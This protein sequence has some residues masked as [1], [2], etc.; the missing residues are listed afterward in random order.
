MGGGV[1]VLVPRTTHCSSGR[2]KCWQSAH[3]RPL[4]NPS[5]DWMHGFEAPGTSWSLKHRMAS[6][7]RGTDCAMNINAAGDKLMRPSLRHVGYTHVAVGLSKYHCLLC[8]T[9]SVLGRI[10]IS[11]LLIIC[12]FSTDSET[13][14]GIKTLQALAINLLTFINPS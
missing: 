11:N 3:Y 14:V 5:G 12:R 9:G 10:F 1:T 6:Y 13:H 8:L 2:T 4:H 7:G